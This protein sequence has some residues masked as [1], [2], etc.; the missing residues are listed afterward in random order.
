M[1]KLRDWDTIKN[2]T[3]GAL[4]VLEHRRKQDARA[5]M[6]QSFRRLRRPQR[7]ALQGLSRDRLPPLR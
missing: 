6:D 7:P 1:R 5:R 4:Q 3:M 2:F